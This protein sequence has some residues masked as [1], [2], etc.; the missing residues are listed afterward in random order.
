MGAGGALFFRGG[1]APC[2][3]RRPQPAQ[4]I[5]QPARQ[6]REPQRRTGSGPAGGGFNGR[7][8]FGRIGGGGARGLSAHRL[9]R[10]GRGRR[11]GLGARQRDPSRV[12]AGTRYGGQ[13]VGGVLREFNQQQPRDRK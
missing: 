8:Q 9:G 2:G 7:R 11:G 4:Q 10:R 13:V 1:R 6:A 12:Q 5:G 3:A